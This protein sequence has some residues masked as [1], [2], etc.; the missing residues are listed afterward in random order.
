MR[1]PSVRAA[2]VSPFLY[3]YKHFRIRVKKVLRLLYFGFKGAIIA[4]LYM[5][6]M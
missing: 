5:Q 1:E 4:L 3:V 2:S 6:T